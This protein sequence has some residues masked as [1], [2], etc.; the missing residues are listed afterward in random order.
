MTANCNTFSFDLGM[1]TAEAVE[2]H[3][4][5]STTCLSRRHVLQRM[6]EAGMA[7]LVSDETSADGPTYGTITV[8][9]GG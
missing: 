8:R 2:D 4:Q 7:T 1:S 6:V 9:I 5:I 3:L